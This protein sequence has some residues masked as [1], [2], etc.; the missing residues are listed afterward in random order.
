M[1]DSKT[2]II[3]DNLILMVVFVLTLILLIMIW[4]RPELTENEGFM[5]LA[6]GIIITGLVNGIIQKTN[7]QQQRSNERVTE[8][9]AAA[10]STPAATAPLPTKVDEVIVETKNTTVNSDVKSEPT[11]DQLA[12]E[13]PW[14]AWVDAPTG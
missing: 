12:A 2:N 13:R 5:Y 1:S 6:T 9:L 11:S 7:T 3:E 4:A 10:A 8:T 14:P